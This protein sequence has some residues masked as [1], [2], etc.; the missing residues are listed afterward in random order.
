MIRHAGIQDVRAFG[1]IINDCA[2]Y[3]LMLLAPRP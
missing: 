2:E 1:K 3:G